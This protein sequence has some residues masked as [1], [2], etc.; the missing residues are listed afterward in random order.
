MF[1]IPTKYHVHSLP[2]SNGC[3]LKWGY[4]STLRS[5]SMS[6]TIVTLIK[7]IC[8]TSGTSLI[9]EASPKVVKWSANAFVVGGNCY[10]RISN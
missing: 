2:Y 10:G 4:T 9:K 3:E 6:S 7:G 1:I 8:T 5:T